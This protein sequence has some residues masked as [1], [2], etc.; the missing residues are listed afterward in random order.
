MIVTNFST[1]CFV[2]FFDV[3]VLCT[4][5]LGAYMYIDGQDPFFHFTDEGLEALRDCMTYPSSQSLG[6]NLDLSLQCLAT[7]LLSPW[8]PP[9]CQESIM[10]S[11]TFGM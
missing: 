10:S 2:L 4:P 3:I 9:L 11:I 1:A 6:L 8:C 7:L 5:D